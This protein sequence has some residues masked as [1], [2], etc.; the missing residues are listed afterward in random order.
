MNEDYQ[1]EPHLEGN[2]PPNH[3][4]AEKAVLGAMMLDEERLHEMLELLET[5]HFYAPSHRKIFEVMKE[6]S[7]LGKRI[8]HL[9]VYAEFKKNGNVAE[10]GGASYIAGLTQNVPTLA[11][12]SHYAVIIKEKSYL[13][14]LLNLT[15]KIQNQVFTSEN[16]DEVYELAESN[17]MKLSEKR[18]KKNSN[19]IASLMEQAMVNFNDRIDGNNQ[20]KGLTCKYWSL[21]KMLN[22]FRGGEMLVIAARPS[23]G[24][25]SFALNLILEFAIR[26]DAPAAFFSLEMG[27]LQIANNMLCIES[28]TDGN[29][30]NNPD[31]AISE[32]DTE[33]IS[34]GIERI[35]GAKII[36]DD[37]SFLSP[38]ILR[39]KL[40]RYIKEHGVKVV[41]ID[42]LQLMSAPEIGSRDGRTQEMS[43]ISRTLKSISRE[44]DI[45]VIALAQLNRGVESRQGNKPRMSDLRES[46]SIEQDADAVMLIHRPDYYNPDEKPGEAEVILAK[47]RNGETGTA[48]FMFIRNM[49]RFENLSN[50]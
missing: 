37:D 24:K 16:A 32:G 48:P 19:D 17:L 35:A 44:M 1:S 29:F 36:I 31:A 23:M 28:S 42:Y 20:N 7:P 5:E 8:D 46:G 18:I 15:M 27:A 25:T 26:Q 40:R 34:R 6:L 21:M 33:R 22:G 38:Q 14:M 10:V 2:S 47:N 49:M 11:N 39:S 50:E 9:L 4:D 43:H 12:A 41:L 3:I 45:P 30:W 13:R